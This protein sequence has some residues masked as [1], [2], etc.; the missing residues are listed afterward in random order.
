MKLVCEEMKVSSTGRKKKRRR[1]ERYRGEDGVIRKE[2]LRFNGQ[3]V[4]I[5]AFYGIF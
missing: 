1:R 3:N 2:G 5:L 4:V